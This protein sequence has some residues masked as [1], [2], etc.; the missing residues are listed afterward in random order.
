MEK[1]IKQKI[2]YSPEHA[3]GYE[4]PIK[5]QKLLEELQELTGVRWQYYWTN[6]GRLEV[7][8]TKEY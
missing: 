1:E 4:D 8:P 2:V 3:R 6:D 7:E 5:R